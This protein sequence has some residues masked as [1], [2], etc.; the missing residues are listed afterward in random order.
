MGCMVVR[1]GPPGRRI[2]GKAPS[3]GPT[4]ACGS[5]G[6]GESSPFEE[7]LL[8]CDGAAGCAGCCCCWADGPGHAP[9]SRTC[10]DG[11]RCRE[12]SCVSSCKLVRGPCPPGLSS[13]GRGWDTACCRWA[14]DCCG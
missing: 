9:G 12:P 5:G 10:M 7:R 2:D 4:S 14:G 8:G 11:R 13:D 1:E 6:N 3:F